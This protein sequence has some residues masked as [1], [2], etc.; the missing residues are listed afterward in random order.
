MVQTHV[1]EVAGDGST[2]AGLRGLSDRGVGDEVLFLGE[3]VATAGDLDWREERLVGFGIRV[4]L[5]DDLRK[6]A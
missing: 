3:L 4:I 2:E 1:A 5:G 6:P